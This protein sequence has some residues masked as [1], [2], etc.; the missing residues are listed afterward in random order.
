M[1][2]PSRFSEIFER[3]AP[4]VEAFIA[5]RIGHAA[6]DDVLSET[7]LVAFRQRKKFD[8]TVESA[9][10]WLL[11][12]ATRMI[13]RHRSDE[14][15]HWRSLVA[16]SQV[17]D[18]SA[19]DEMNG[20]SDRVDAA[21]AVRELG[22]LISGLSRRDRDTLLLYAWGDLTYEQ[23]AVA[24]NV[25]V[26][27]VRSRLSRIRT[28]LSTPPLAVPAVNQSWKVEEKSNERLEQGA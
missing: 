3:H 15:A 11:G 7:F 12:I 20:V 1:S 16:S 14:A 23:I 26:G 6:K 2:T 24:L 22:P 27:T 21:A 13:K 25:P 9:R 5:S 28:R 19:P 18:T 4:N 17:A 8:L 10:P